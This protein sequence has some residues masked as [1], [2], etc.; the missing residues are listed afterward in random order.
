MQEG[1][2][3]TPYKAILVYWL[4]AGW[5]DWCGL[6]RK[7]LLAEIAVS[8][9]V[10]IVGPVWAH[11]QA[12]DDATG[13]ALVHGVAGSLVV[14]VVLAGLY[15]IAAL[16]RA[17]FRSA[18][19]HDDK[20]AKEQVNASEE[21]SL[22]ESRGAQILRLQKS[23]RALERKRSRA[24]YR[25]EKLRSV[26]HRNRERSPTGASISK[27]PLPTM[28]ESADELR[29]RCDKLA[30]AAS[31]AAWDDTLTT[32]Q[33][34]AQATELYEATQRMLRDGLADSRFGDEIESLQHRMRLPFS[35]VEGPKRRP[36]ARAILDSL[37]D[38]LGDEFRGRIDPEHVRRLGPDTS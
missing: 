11:L 31:R 30:D 19:H 20:L 18:A 29:D 6:L 8:T 35:A 12:P 25:V 32:E 4:W 24:E 16:V 22:A 34:E 21:R 1:Q 2:R 9:A 28:S 23:L 5:A 36:A 17:P 7:H 27:G 37:S 13:S 15:L 33:R 26:A 14:L 10:L 38:W 3:Y